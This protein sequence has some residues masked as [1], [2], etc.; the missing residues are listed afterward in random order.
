MS[1]APRP[2]IAVALARGR[3]RSP[4]DRHGV[5]VARQHDERHARPG[6]TRGA[7]NSTSSLVVERPRSAHG[8]DRP[9]VAASARPRRCHST[10]GMSTSASV[11]TASRSARPLGHGGAVTAA[12]RARASTRPR[13]RGTAS[14]VSSTSPSSRRSTSRSPPGNRTL[15]AGTSPA[16]L[17]ATATAH[18]PAAARHRLPAASLPH[19]ACDDRPRR[20]W[21]NSTFVCSGNSSWRSSAG[22][23]WPTW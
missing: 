17:A 7:T 8:G 4:R 11:R 15:R 13:R 9:D 14:P 16:S 5:D 12:E 21:A 18:G 22:P 2:T 1:A 10:D 19:R 3:A 23:M 6:G 20:T